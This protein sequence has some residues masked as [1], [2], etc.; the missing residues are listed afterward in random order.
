[1]KIQLIKYLL[2][3]KPESGGAHASV[4]RLKWFTNMLNG[5]CLFNYHVHTRA[6]R[7][8]IYPHERFECVLERRRIAN[9]KIELVAVPA[10]TPIVCDMIS[11]E[12]GFQFT[13]NKNA[14]RTRSF[15]R[16]QRA[17]L[18]VVFMRTIEHKN[19]LMSSNC[20]CAVA[21]FRTRLL[22]NWKK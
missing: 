15:Q 3:L 4:V 17:I 12:H 8:W 16:W 22:F 7:W 21:F 14:N 6:A 20:R 18:A 11:I 2:A 13:S 5:A 9:C 1:M 19:P 10:F